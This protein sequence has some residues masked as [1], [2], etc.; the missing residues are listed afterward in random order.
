MQRGRAGIAAWMLLALT[1]G[2]GSPLHA[3]TVLVLSQTG[4]KLTAIDSDSRE[5]RASLDVAKGP[6][7]IALSP[8]GRRAYIAHSDLGEVSVVDIKAW[9]VDQTFKVPGAPFG[10]AVSRSHK[11]YVGDWNS[12]QVHELDADSGKILS[13]AIAGKAPAHLALTP[14]GK[15][16][17]AAAR[18]ADLVSIFETDDFSD[19]DKVDVEKAPFALAI[20]HKGQ[21]AI[22]ANAQS[23]SASVIDLAQRKVSFTAKVGA[24][25]Y[26]VAFTADDAS[27]IVTN[28]QSGTVSILTDKASDSVT[29][30]GSYP[31]GIAITPDDKHAYVANW[32]SDDVSVVDIATAKEIARIKIP[33]GPRAVVMVP[34]GDKP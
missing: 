33:G 28:Q 21:Q 9:R 7:N 13:S 2:Y 18:E 23:G 15:L 26:G 6:A 20:S 31:E 5:I 3:G 8:D 19:G 16:L 32:F 12:D 25:P 30:V 14:D 27:V 11:L 1:S 34:G 10:L 4:A 17:V 22:V 29:K 24:M